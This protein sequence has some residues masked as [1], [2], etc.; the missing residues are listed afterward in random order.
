MYAPPVHIPYHKRAATST[1]NHG[2]ASA[3]RTICAVV[4][5]PDQMDLPRI[6]SMVTVGAA[7]LPD[8]IRTEPLQSVATRRST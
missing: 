8:V 7:A 2:I 5:D 1:A 6:L 4:P 3:L